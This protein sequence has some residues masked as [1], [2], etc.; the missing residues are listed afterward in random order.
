MPCVLPLQR[1]ASDGGELRN[2]RCPHIVDGCTYMITR[3]VFER[4]VSQES[5]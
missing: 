2:N 1:N 5:G 4:L 3:F